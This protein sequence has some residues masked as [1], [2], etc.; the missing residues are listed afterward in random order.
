MLVAV[1]VR[2]SGGTTDPRGAPDEVFVAKPPARR[3][4]PHEGLVVEA[5]RQQAR[6]GVVDGPDIEAKRRPPIL[7]G[8]DQTVEQLLRRSAYVGFGARS[9]VKL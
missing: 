2:R 9:A 1:G 5:C 4:R 6:Q 7:T 8:G 3:R